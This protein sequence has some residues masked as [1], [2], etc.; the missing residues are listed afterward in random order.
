L[1][2]VEF[3]S[4]TVDKIVPLSGGANPE[5]QYDIADS[6]ASFLGLDVQVIKK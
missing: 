2:V 6:V 3:K 5:K 4:S 1:G